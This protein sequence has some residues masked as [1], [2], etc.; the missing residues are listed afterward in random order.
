MRTLST[1]VLVLLLGVAVSAQAWTAY[2]NPRFGYSLR[3]PATLQLSNRANDRS[4]LT[5]QTGTFRV[6]ASGVNNPYSIK[7][8]EYFEDIRVAAAD[9]VVEERDCFRERD[10]MA[11]EQGRY[12]HEILYTKDGRRVHQKTFIAGGSINTLEVSYAYRYRKQ[13]ESIA[14]EILG[15]FKPGDLGHQH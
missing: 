10:M 14:K 7:P 4:G 11:Q 13:K 15:T 3:L 8:H 6:Q 2:R 1:L 5:W 12:W 9:R